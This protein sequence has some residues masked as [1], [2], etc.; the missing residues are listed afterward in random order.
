MRC[1]ILSNV[2]ITAITMYENNSVTKPW[3]FLENMEREYGTPKVRKIL[4]CTN[5]YIYENK[6]NYYILFATTVKKWRV[7]TLDTEAR[8][9]NLF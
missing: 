4:K 2:I 1:C 6:H 3:P 9:T 8:T 7:D 5:V